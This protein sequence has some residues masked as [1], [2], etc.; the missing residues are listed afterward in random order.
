LEG[1]DASRKRRPLS[2]E[3]LLRTYRDDSDKKQAMV[4]KADITRG[5]LTFVVE[6]L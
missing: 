5:R 6:A 4:R 1:L 3:R 2:V